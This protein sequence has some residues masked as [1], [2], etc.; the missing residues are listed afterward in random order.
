MYVNLGVAL[1]APDPS[2]NTYMVALS[3]LMQNIDELEDSIRAETA[4]QQRIMDESQRASEELADLKQLCVCVCPSS[5][6]STDYQLLLSL[7]SER[8]PTLM[9][10]LG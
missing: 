5:H 2:V 7:S 3:E 1:Q 9:H 4:L 6:S 8:Q 10:N